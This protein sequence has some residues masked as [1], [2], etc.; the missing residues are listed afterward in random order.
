MKAKPAK[1][2]AAPLLERFLVQWLLKEIGFYLLPPIPFLPHS[3]F[4]PLLTL[5]QKQFEK[6][7]EFLGIYELAHITRSI[8]DKKTLHAIES[9]LEKEQ[10]QFYQ[11]ARKK[12]DPTPPVSFKIDSKILLN[13]FS[14]SRG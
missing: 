5:K 13:S 1:H 3:D 2:P 11:I 4:I 14:I 7:F 10:V 6:L 12:R 9:N 8:V